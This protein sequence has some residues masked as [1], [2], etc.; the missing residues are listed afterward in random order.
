MSEYNPYAAPTAALTEVKTGIWREGDVLRMSKDAT[1]P[2]RCV[3]CN[4]PADKKLNR[5]LRWHP[6][7]WY[8][9]IIFPGLLIYIIIAMVVSHRAKISVPMCARHRSRRR[10]AIAVGWLVCLASFFVLPIIGAMTSIPTEYVVGGCVA[11]FA[12]WLL[13]GLIRSN[14]VTPALIDKNYV[15]LKGINRDFL[16]ALAYGEV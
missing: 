8:F 10:W 3:K 6:P 1:L 16:D 11:M 15:W 14:V 12:A 7:G 13:Y 9:T 4:A 2:N 5:E